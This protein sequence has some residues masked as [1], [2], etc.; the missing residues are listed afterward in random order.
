[1][2]VSDWLMRVTPDGSSKI[3]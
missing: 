2:T 3:D 1:V